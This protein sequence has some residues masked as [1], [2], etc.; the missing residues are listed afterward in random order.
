MS[1]DTTS[2]PHIHSGIR[3]TGMMVRV[4]SALVPAII[5]YT[6]FFGWGLSINILIAITTALCT[7]ALMLKLRQRPLA[8]FLTDGSAVVTGLL[9]A[10]CIP[11]FSPWWITVM[12]VVFAIVVA[13][14]LY[15]GLGYNPF[16]P[17][18]VG[19][20]MLLISFPLEMTQWVPPNIVNQLQIGFL[21]TL[22]IIFTGHFP[23]LLSIDALSMATPLDTVKTELGLNITVTEIIRSNAQ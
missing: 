23:Y 7:E 21:D 22:N 16:N 3:I 8:P 14:H 13:K 11:P 20:V 15:G 12:G 1:L 18:M 9:L 2:S 4:C 17:A 5:A 6:W 19:Y 10:F